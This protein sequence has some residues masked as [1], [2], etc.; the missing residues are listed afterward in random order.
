MY[1]F[2]KVSG[3]YVVDI[4]KHTLTILNEERNVEIHVGTDS[5]NVGSQTVYCTAVAYRYSGRGVH[6]IQYIQKVDRITDNWVRLW[7]E[8]EMSIEVAQWLT[9]KIPWI[10]LQIDLDYNSDGSY[11][12]NKL[13]SSAGGWAS[14]LG[15]TVNVKPNSQIATK[16]AD[17]SCR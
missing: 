6:Y 9:Q 10:K 14:S 8:A 5:Q 16:A 15:F 4:A 12:S 17:N 11:F 2:K 7:K 3:E 1:P 13:I